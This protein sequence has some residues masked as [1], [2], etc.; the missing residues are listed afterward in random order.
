[1]EGKTNEKEYETAEGVEEIG[2]EEEGSSRRS[3]M[4]KGA[5][6][7][8]AVALGSAASAGTAAARQGDS[9]LV[10]TYNYYPGA[11]WQVISQLPQT[12]V[13]NILGTTGGTGGGGGRPRGNVPEISQPD[14]YV[15]YVIRYNLGPGG[16]ITAMVFTRDGTLQVGSGGHQFRA[17]AQVFS[18]NLNLVQV[19]QDR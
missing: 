4:K 15:G 9:F 16:G 10:F 13:V 2:E 14:E 12:T 19:T 11:S 6:A 1:M 8:G 7:A 5:A 3:F 17:D 18:A